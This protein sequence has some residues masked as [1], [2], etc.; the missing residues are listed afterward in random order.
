MM[1]SEQAFPGGRD[2]YS[3]D[4]DMGRSADREDESIPG[5]VSSDEDDMTEEELVAD[6]EEEDPILTEEDLE[7]NDLTDEEAE[8][9]DWDEPQR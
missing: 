3:N 5:S 1:I 4:N 9:V 2:Q 6:S 8:D 7:E